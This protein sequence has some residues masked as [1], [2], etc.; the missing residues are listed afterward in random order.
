[1]IFVCSILIVPAQLV[2]A[3]K[4]FL[5]KNRAFSNTEQKRNNM[6]PC[7]RVE[8]KRKKEEKTEALPYLLNRIPSQP[9][10]GNLPLRTG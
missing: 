6:E 1:M 3:L 5:I 9:E 4:F 8:A 10:F 7:R 2:V